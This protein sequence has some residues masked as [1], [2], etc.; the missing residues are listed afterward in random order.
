VVFAAVLQ[1]G[2]DAA[3]NATGFGALYFATSAQHILRSS[4]FYSPGAIYH[5]KGS[6][7]G[8]NIKG[9]ENEALTLLNNYFDA[10]TS[11]ARAFVFYQT[12]PV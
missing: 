9:A 11:Y 6:I 8:I 12:A 3:F 10:G 1:E 4:L 5:V 7:T 2:V